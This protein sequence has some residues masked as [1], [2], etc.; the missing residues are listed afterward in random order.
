MPL[1]KYYCDHCQKYFNYSVA[2]RKKH[3]E[4]PRHKNLVKLHYDAYK[5]MPP[6]RPRRTVM[7]C[8]KLLRTGICLQGA[9]CRFSH[10]YEVLAAHYDQT[11]CD[12]EDTT[13]GETKSSG[14][15]NSTQTEKHS[16]AT[17]HPPT[18]YHIPPQLE[19]IED[20]LPPSLMPPPIGG[21]T[22]NGSAV[23]G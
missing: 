14:E 22:F 17:V 23:W 3:F 7:P 12:S 9:E 16:T 19:A 11:Q 20:S 1:P 6:E 18:V 13:V 2:N 8:Q 5:Y 21:Y 4:S 15:A 10:S